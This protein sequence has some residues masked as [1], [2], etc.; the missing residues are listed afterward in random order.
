MAVGSQ[1]FIIIFGQQNIMWLYIM[2]INSQ[3]RLTEVH[4]YIFYV[5]SSCCSFANLQ[6][7]FVYLFFEVDNN[8][9]TVCYIL[10]CDQLLYEMKINQKH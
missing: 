1:S 10:N 8:Y 3:N 6:R 7:S 5:D 4:G 9:Y 2:H